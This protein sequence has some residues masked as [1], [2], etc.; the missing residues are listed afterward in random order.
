MPW[1][2]VVPVPVPT[3]AETLPPGA[4]ISGLMAPSAMRG[5]RDDDATI[6]S[7]NAMKRSG[8]TDVGVPTTA[9]SATPSPW[10]VEYTG[11]V[12]SPPP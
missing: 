11:T 9:L 4:A 3:R 5:P 2:A 7:A 8:P 6:S 1:K 12:T 10:V